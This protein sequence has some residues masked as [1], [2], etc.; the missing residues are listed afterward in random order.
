M[1]R[2]RYEKKMRAILTKCHMI[3]KQNGR[4]TYKAGKALSVRGYKLPAGKSYQECWDGVA[5]ALADLID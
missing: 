1:T 5:R 4:I 2:K 3:N